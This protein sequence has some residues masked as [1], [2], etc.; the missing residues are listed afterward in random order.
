M[1][2]G[3]GVH[4]GSTGWNETKNAIFVSATSTPCEVDPQPDPPLCFLD[5]EHVAKL[6][7]SSQIA[8]KRGPEEPTAAPED[9]L[10]PGAVKVDTFCLAGL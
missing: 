8:E 7:E 2:C 4:L 9:D 5:P 10:S 6:A 1:G 3:P